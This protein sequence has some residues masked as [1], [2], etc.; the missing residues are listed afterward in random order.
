M[1]DYPIVLVTWDD[2]WIDTDL[3]TIEEIQ[4]MIPVTRVTIGWL[5]DGTPDDFGASLKIAGEI[6]PPS[7]HNPT[8]NLYSDIT[9][10]PCAWITDVKE[11]VVE[12]EDEED[13]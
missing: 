5:L 3:R 12:E 1:D 10:I 9:L 6:L 4:N 2:A 11:I 7:F 8:C 13:D